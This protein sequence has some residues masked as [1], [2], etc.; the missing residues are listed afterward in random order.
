MAGARFLDAQTC[1]LTQ[2]LHMSSL[3]STSGTRGFRIGVVI[4]NWL[5][6]K[7]AEPILPKD[8]WLF[9]RSYFTF[10]LARSARSLRLLGEVL[11]LTHDNS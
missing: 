1:P 9:R 11:N 8:V 2:S 10:P 6:S 3:S 4:L 5:P 7:A